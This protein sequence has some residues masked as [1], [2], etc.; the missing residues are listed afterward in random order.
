MDYLKCMNESKQIKIDELEQLTE[1]LLKEKNESKKY[2][3]EQI[4]Y[5]I[6][7]IEYFNSIIHEL[8]DEIRLIKT[9]ND[10]L[11]EQSQLR[12]SINPD[13]NRLKLLQ[14]SI[15]GKLHTIVDHSEHEFNKFKIHL[16]KQFQDFLDTSKQSF[17]N[18]Q[19][20]ACDELL[21]DI[22][23]VRTWT[24]YDSPENRNSVSSQSSVIIKKGIGADFG[25]FQGIMFKSEG[26]S[27]RMQNYEPSIESS[28]SYLSSKCQPCVSKDVELAFEEKK[29]ET[30]SSKKSLHSN[31]I[32]IPTTENTVYDKNKF[33][34]KVESI[35]GRTK[36]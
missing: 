30:K 15:G 29:Y 3:D 1:H 4:K 33:N 20:K 16:T 13:E 19:G 5:H 34:F 21:S 28:R 32:T 23:N 18:F 10:Y 26:N 27:S 24:G 25:Q 14:E 12:I 17:I 2:Y 6:Q 11:K 9:E 31:A 7:Q 8:R 22:S 36:S 35:N